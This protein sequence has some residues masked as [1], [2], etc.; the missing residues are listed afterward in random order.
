MSKK[1]KNYFEKRKKINE[2][3]Y[4]IDENN[5]FYLTLPK[6]NKKE[7]NTKIV[8]DKK[9]IIPVYEY[10]EEES[11]MYKYASFNS[12][13]SDSEVSNIDEEEKKKLLE[14]LRTKENFKKK[15]MSP[16]KS[17]SVNLTKPLKFNLNS[18][19]KLNEKLNFLTIKES[20]LK[21]IKK[22]RQKLKIVKQEDKKRLTEFE[23]FNYDKKKWI[24]EN[25]KLSDSIQLNIDEFEKKR[26][27]EMKKIFDEENADRVL[28]ERGK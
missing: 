24:K 19:F 17:N 10:T 18:Q 5:N 15:Q 6:F 3:Q 4:S 25:L 21:N 27:K 13:D 22:M 23:L 9:Q 11:N 7:E 28:I 16:I 14:R 26:Y 12:S 20:A 1:Y 2:T 8:Q